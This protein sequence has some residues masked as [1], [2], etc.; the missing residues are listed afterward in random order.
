MASRREEDS[1]MPIRIEACEK[2]SDSKGQ[3]KCEMLY[4]KKTNKQTLQN[5]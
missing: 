4:F 1:L 3:A 5:N 2:I